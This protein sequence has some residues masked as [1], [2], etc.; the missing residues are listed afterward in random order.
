MNIRQ[1]IPADAEKLVEL[2]KRVEDSG[3]MMFDPGERKT[4]AAQFKKRI[5][6]IDGNSAIFVAEEQEDLTGYLFAIGEN[7]IRKSHSVYVAIGV[8]D[9][10]RGTGIGTKLFNALDSWAANK[11]LHRIELT[12]MER[13][14]A[15]IALYK[16]VGFEVEG[17]KRDSLLVNGNYVDELYMAKIL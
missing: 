2:I 10:Q 16:K 7:L 12:V 4:T 8:R 9:G 6:S 1:A 5:E 13:N 11:E 15:G 17:R 14:E 3:T